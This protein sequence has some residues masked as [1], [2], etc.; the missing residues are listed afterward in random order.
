MTQESKKIAIISRS[1]DESSL[2]EATYE[3]A[4]AIF[5]NHKKDLCSEVKE[6]A[7]ASINGDKSKTFYSSKLVA[8]TLNAL[9]VENTDK[10]RV[11]YYGNPKK[12]VPDE[13][14][15]VQFKAEWLN[16][17]KLFLFD[18]NI[19]PS[20][21]N[22]TLSDGKLIEKYKVIDILS[23]FAPFKERFP[24]SSI[25]FIDYDEYFDGARDYETILN[26]KWREGVT[27]NQK[28]NFILNFVRDW[29]VDTNDI[30]Y[31]LTEIT[32]KW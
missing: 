26:N 13:R 23:F 8:S 9:L 19:A 1:Y 7:E 12:G 31:Q 18:H 29:L 25:T 16:E 28:I 5:N 4:K 11:L 22:S 2:C 21:L 15:E 10:L 14:P 3:N 30:N 6:I 24:N 32:P 17:L 20:S 27:E